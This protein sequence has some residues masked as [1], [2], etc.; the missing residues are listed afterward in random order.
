MRRRYLG[1]TVG[2]ADGWSA[3]AREAWRTG[4]RRDGKQA[5]TQLVPARL[6]GILPLNAYVN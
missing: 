3:A 1:D 5:T 4:I 6:L 2:E